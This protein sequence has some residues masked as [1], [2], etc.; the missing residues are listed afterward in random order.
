MC[1]FKAGLELARKG[2]EDPLGT[3]CIQDNASTEDT[4]N[5]VENNE[6]AFEN[7]DVCEAKEVEELDIKSEID[8]FEEGTTFCKSEVDSYSVDDLHLDQ[9]I[10]DSF[11]PEVKEDLL[12]DGYSSDDDFNEDEHHQD[13]FTG[14]NSSLH[15]SL[16]ERVLHDLDLMHLR[17]AHLGRY[18]CKLCNYRQ[19]AH[20]RFSHVDSSGHKEAVKSLSEGPTIYFCTIARCKFSSI[21]RAE[22]E[23]HH[24]IEHADWLKHGMLEP[25]TEYEIVGMRKLEKRNKVRR[26][27]TLFISAKCYGKLRSH[28]LLSVCR[29]K[30]KRDEAQS[31]QEAEPL[32]YEQLDHEMCEA[33]SVS[34]Y[35]CR[36]CDISGPGETTSLHSNEEQHQSL[37][38][39]MEF[40]PSFFCSAFDC[41][42]Q[43]VDPDSFKCHQEESHPQELSFSV[44]TRH[45][46]LV[47]LRS[48]ISAYEQFPR[49]K[50]IIVTYECYEQLRSDR[51]FDLPQ[52][53]YART[54]GKSDRVCDE[55]GK[56]ISMYHTMEEHKEM[57]HNTKLCDKCDYSA[58][59]D[60][61]LAKHMKS[62]HRE[63]CNQCGLFITARERNNRHECPN[64]L[65]PG[66]PD[67]E[68]IATYPKARTI[69]DRRL[70]NGEILCIQCGFATKRS[71]T[72]RQHIRLVHG[73]WDCSCTKGASGDTVVHTC[74][75][76]QGNHICDICGHRSTTSCNL[77]M[78]KRRHEPK[79]LN[80]ECPH[81]SK[82]FCKSQVLQNHIKS[83]HLK[84]KRKK[85]HPC[86]HC[87]YIS[88]SACHLERHC[89]KK[90]KE[91]L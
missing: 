44:P 56:T 48:N 42:Y 22:V 64:R 67:P 43:H 40:E 66:P 51:G 2:E 76:L 72:M 73:K 29:T 16:Q 52:T 62:A 82:K 53:T 4:P 10:Y 84:I 38:N 86:P 23:K 6:G 49:G 35:V 47:K 7:L 63:T 32:I 18:I 59:S 41:K 78:H 89:S 11:D 71:I 91:Y 50:N 90:H 9:D 39:N 77:K 30:R 21:V 8:N 46:F 17:G 14:L 27:H 24:E 57:W 75:P 34:E 45:F 3:D 12:N 31:I 1:F 33:F 88:Y 70:P 68:I 87:D 28:T 85:N 83:V 13:D 5:E 20:K 25:L 54:L 79:V 36:L 81:C 55:C 60:Y 37:V 19:N 15:P 80:F 74:Q 65:G 69:N 58:Q 26:T 61:D